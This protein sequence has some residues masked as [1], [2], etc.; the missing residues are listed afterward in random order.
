MVYSRAHRLLDEGREQGIKQGER[1]GTIESILA[2][3]GARFQS[4]T[5]QALKPAIE[6]IDD[7][8]RLRELLLAAYKAQSVDAFTKTLYQ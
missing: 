8:Q 6:A 2:L 3:L 5:V 4:E 7:L 1:K